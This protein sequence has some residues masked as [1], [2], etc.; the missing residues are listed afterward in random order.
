MHEVYGPLKPL[1]AGHLVSKAF[2][3]CSTGRQRVQT[4][5][6]SIAMDVDAQNLVFQ[7]KAGNTIARRRVWHGVWCRDFLNPRMMRMEGQQTRHL[8]DVELVSSWEFQTA[9][10]WVSHFWPFERFERAKPSE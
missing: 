3:R 5:H 2:L 8:V 1:T 10:D 6:A 4:V 9:I 7:E